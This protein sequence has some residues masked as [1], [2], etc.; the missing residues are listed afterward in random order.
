[1]A[2]Q[3]QTS[4]RVEIFKTVVL[5]V[6]AVALGIAVLFCVIQVGNYNGHAALLQACLDTKSTAAG[7]PSTPVNAGQIA[8]AHNTADTL[9]SIG[10]LCT[11]ML[12]FVV[13]SEI[14]DRLRRS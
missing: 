6:F 9:G 13:G 8:A 1:M 2:P 11:F 7:C 3:Q 5:A 4:A 10:W 12:L 14:M